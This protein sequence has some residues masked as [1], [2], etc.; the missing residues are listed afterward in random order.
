MAGTL[1]VFAALDSPIP[2]RSFETTTLERAEADGRL[3]FLVIGASWCPY[4][5]RLLRRLA[6][7]VETQAALH[8]S[9]VPI[10]VDGDDHSAIHTRY[11]GGGWPSI[12][13]CTADGW[14]I[15][16]GTHVD[17][18]HFPRLLRSLADQDVGAVPAPSPIELDAPSPA[19][20]A[21]GILQAVRDAYDPVSRG[22]ALEAEAAGPRFSHFDAIELLLEH[23]V[24]GDRTI[25]LD[26]LH[27]IMDR[28]WDGAEGG[29][30]RYAAAPDWSDVH[31]EKL[32]VDQATLIATL[33]KAS[34]IDPQF[35]ESAARAL[36]WTVEQFRLNDGA[37]AAS[38]RPLHSEVPTAWPVPSLDTSTPIDW[39]ARLVS[40]QLLLAETTGDRALREK[41]STLARR[42]L[43]HVR[44]GR[45]PHRVRDDVACGG[46]LADETYLAL[47]A[48]DAGLGERA[49]VIVDRALSARR[50]ADGSFA[51][52]H[53]DQ[54]GPG[55]LRRPIAPLR[56]NAVF[57]ELC[58]RFGGGYLETGREILAATSGAASRAGIMASRYALAQSRISAVRSD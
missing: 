33:A 24:A 27:Q 1:G 44:D 43:T 3:L 2:W 26:A 41:A 17:P 39:N 49:R 48:F 52:I 51:D 45:V 54:P 57:A 21:D 58:A 7:D 23:G 15:W 55:L 19:A 37:F 9:Y 53:L 28:L 10:L 11:T 16:R 38:L 5:Q 32:L 12:A 50:L 30:Q 47:A 14:P 22:F 20:A 56:E 42:L 4:S 46:S 25:A 34:T 36:E 31:G 29:L 35:R 18:G 8:E 6:H 40:A 13:I